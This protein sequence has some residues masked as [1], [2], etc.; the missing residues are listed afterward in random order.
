[1]LRIET[2]MSSM[3]ALSRAALVLLILLT[4][5]GWRQGKI[6]RLPPAKLHDALPPPTISAAPE[7]SPA[8]AASA[9]PAAEGAPAPE[10]AVGPAQ[11]AAAS[12]G[13]EESAQERPPGTEATPPSASEA[14]AEPGTEPAAETATPTP[15]PEP[16]APNWPR[17]F[18]AGGTTFEVHQPQVEDWDG[19]TLLADSIVVAKPDGEARPVVGLVRIEAGTRIDE[20][21][22]IVMLESLKLTDAGFPAAPEKTSEW[23]EALRATAAKQFKPIR[24][25]AFK[26]SADIAAALQRAA[27]LRENPVP[28]IILSRRPAVLVAVDGEPIFVPV[29]DTKLTGVRNTRA[30]VLKDA[31]GKVY[32]RLYDGWVSAASLRGPWALAKAPPGA[33]AALRLAKQTGRAQLLQGESDTKTSRKPRLDAKALPLIAVATTPMVLIVIDGEPQFEAIPGTNLRYVTNTAGDVFR[34]VPNKKLY[35]LADGSWYRAGSAAGPWERVPA[36]ALPQDFSRIPAD[37]AKAAVLGAVFQTKTPAALP[38]PEVTE[39]PRS[40]AK[41]RVTIDGNPRLVA[42]PGTQLNY[43]ANASAPIIQLDI[44]HWY[45]FQGGVWFE[46]GTVTGPWT[47][48]DNVPSQIYSIPPSSP[49]YHAVQARVLASSTTSVYYG[50]SAEYYQA[51]T[52]ATAGVSGHATYYATPMPGMMWGWYY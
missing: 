30:I 17:Q 50:Y 46:A 33:D 40:Q 3:L 24:L 39:V 6:E 20:A 31:A 4:A 14:A 25:A 21:Q 10:A 26:S 32:L 13:G 27:A 11:Q 42:I 5:C 8:P 37:S 9:A 16:A 18:V 48:T 2:T 15:T 34:D 7:G 35:V 45:G 41:F 12:P 38:L 43:V 28:R 49:V 29:P 52:G 23:L 36:K 47:V 1:M 44:N 19:K 22:G 51:T